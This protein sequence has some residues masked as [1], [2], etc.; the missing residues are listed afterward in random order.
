M[1]T[2]LLMMLALPIFGSGIL[3]YF[4]REQLA[5]EFGPV[6]SLLAI[7]VGF[8]PGAFIVALSFWAAHGYATGDTEIWSGAITGKTRDHGTYERPYDCN[9]RSITTCSFSGKNQSCST[10]QQCDTCY[11]TH[12]TVK[13]N[14][15]ST[16]GTFDIDSKD[17]TYRSVYE[18]PN[19]QRWLSIATGDPVSKKMPYTNYVQAVPDSLFK[20][21]SESLKA[22]FAK[23]IPMYPD[24]VFDIYHVNRFVQVGFSFTDSAAWNQDINNM[25]RTLGPVKQVNVIVLVAKTNDPNYMYAVRDAWEGANKNDVVVLM[26]S[27]DGQKIEWVDVISWTKSEIFKVELRDSIRELGVIDRAKIMPMIEAQISKNFVRRR[28]REFEYLS[29]EID[30]PTWLLVSIFV[31]LCVGYA[32]G[33]LVSS[34]VA[35]G[36]VSKSKSK[37]KS[38]M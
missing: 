33:A 34:R 10:A 23:M 11:E 20:P 6:L 37:S 31:V 29:T 22:Q 35:V 32:G 26:G 15:Q 27:E 28:M 24:N 4:M 2:T 9:C 21:S 8:L 25:L 19:P 13:W 14:C 30:P 18:S 12:Y 5:R 16:I 3:F 7:L 17:S 38:Y 1:N 36:S